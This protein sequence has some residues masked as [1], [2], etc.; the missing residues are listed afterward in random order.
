MELQLKIIKRISLIIKNI[1]RFL[2]TKS[3]IGFSIAIMQIPALKEIATAAAALGLLMA[4]DDPRW[5]GWFT[6]P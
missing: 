4:E 5:K 6:R 2:A 1:G 3:G